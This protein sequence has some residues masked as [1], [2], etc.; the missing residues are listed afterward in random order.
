MHR[1]IMRRQ[2]EAWC[3]VTHV[4]SGKA[5]ALSALRAASGAGDRFDVVLLD[6]PLTTGE[7]TLANAIK[8][9]ASLDG[10]RVIG[11]APVSGVLSGAAMREADLD[12]C[13]AKPVRQAR[14]REALSHVFGSAVLD[15]PRAA[16]S[17]IPGPKVAVPASLLEARILLAEDNIVNRSVAL[18]QLRTLGC[19]ARS[20]TNGREVLEVLEREAYDIV[21][22]DCQMPELDGYE[23]TQAIRAWEKDP[24]R[25]RRWRAPLR[26]IAMTANALEGD[27]ERC[28]LAGMNQFVTKPVVLAALRAA[29]EEWEP[30]VCVAST[31]SGGAGVADS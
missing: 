17:P 16:G 24:T 23:T 9:D 25:I 7:P 8:A 1:E 5:E 20:V 10:T 2:L 21:L 3:F 28:L 19:T 30:P 6:L 11:L 15:T 4:V 31:P 29:L 27:R 14:L 22:M 18:G 26:I 12:A 13:I